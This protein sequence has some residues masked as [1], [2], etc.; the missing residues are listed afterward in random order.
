MI[1]VVFT[2]RPPKNRFQEPRAK[3][4]FNFLSPNHRV[5]HSTEKYCDNFIQNLNNHTLE[6]KQ[7]LCFVLLDFSQASRY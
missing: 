6:K 7:I 1:A 4:K 5:E 2:K 3:P